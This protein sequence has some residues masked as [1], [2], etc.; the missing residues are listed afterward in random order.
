MGC[1]GDLGTLAGCLWHGSLK[2]Y[3]AQC[4]VT[5]WIWSRDMTTKEHYI[6]PLALLLG[7][8]GTKETIS[9]T[10]IL[11]VIIEVLGNLLVQGSAF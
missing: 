1:V 7:I 2:V 10:V 6:A 5:P 3:C 11:S 8:E 9:A 4:F